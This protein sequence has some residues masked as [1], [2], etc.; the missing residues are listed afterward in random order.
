MIARPQFQVIR[1]KFH[2]PALK[3][4]AE[5]AESLGAK[6][7]L[8]YL[9]ATYASNM[10]SQITTTGL[11]MSIHTASP[12]NTGANEIVGSGMSGYS[13][14]GY[15]GLRQ[16]IIWGSVTNGVVPTATDTQTF[17]LLA[18]QAGGIPY[19]GL[20]TDTGASGHAGTYIFSN[21][22]SGLSGSIPSGANVTFAPAAL[23]LTQA[24]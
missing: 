10:L 8:T 22:T 21:P 13:S 17:A 16:T 15:T 9:A 4:L 18:T 5:I 11:Y 12:S 24:G 23:V 3:A 14:G 2:D 19:Y 6:M 1:H 7:A 20:W